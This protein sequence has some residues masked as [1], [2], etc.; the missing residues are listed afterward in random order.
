MAKS[1]SKSKSKAGP[2]PAP[3]FGGG[4]VAAG[5]SGPVKIRR[6]AGLSGAQKQFNK[7]VE[8]RDRERRQLGEWREAIAAY[9]RRYAD[10]YRPLLRSYE[11]LQS[12]LVLA[13]DRAHANAGLDDGDRARIK[14]IICDVAGEL[15]EEQAD[16]AVKQLYNKYSGGDYDAEVAA[17]EGVVAEAMR[18]EFGVDLERDST[19]EMA[20]RIAEKWRQEMEGDAPRPGG[21][22]GAERAALVAAHQAMDVPG[23]LALR[24]EIEQLDQAAVN[25][26]LDPDLQRYAQVLSDEIA[27][28]RSEIENVELVFKAEYDIPPFPELPPAE[29]SLD[30]DDDLE[31]LQDDIDELEGDL[32]D[33]R[34]MSSLKAWLIYR[35]DQ[36]SERGDDDDDDDSDVDDALLRALDGILGR[37]TRNPPT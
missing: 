23:Q 11:E 5:R 33:I 6:G 35:H 7:L 17:Q 30:L 26:L 1:K 9:E 29:L 34:D 18:Q 2:A 15:L 37:R 27:E 28:L 8:L 20:A 21:G 10:E 19:Q 25:A 4:G 36:L 14:D 31:V 13:L 3:A 16:D 32:D 12:R 22:E 24:R